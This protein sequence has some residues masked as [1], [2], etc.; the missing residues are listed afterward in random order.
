CDLLGQEALRRTRMVKKRIGDVLLESGQITE[1][2]LNRALAIQKEKKV[3]LG[4]ALLQTNI[5]KTNI[6]KAI[7]EVQGVPFIECPDYIASDVLGTVPRAIAIRCCAL[8]LKV[9]NDRIL[10]VAL[11]DPQNLTHLDELQFCSGK[12]ISPRFSFTEDIVAAIKRF[13]G[14]DRFAEF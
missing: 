8:P 4:E 6:A 1:Q 11:A 9:V 14:E 12:L 7:E 5:A 13:Y 3:R 10:I 2:D